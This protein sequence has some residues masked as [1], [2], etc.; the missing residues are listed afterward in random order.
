MRSSWG[1]GEAALTGE[2]TLL[3]IIGCAVVIFF[4][5]LALDGIES[6][7]EGARAYADRCFQQLLFA[8]DGAYFASNLS[9]KARPGYP[10]NNQ[11]YLIS[12]LT[13]L[14]VPSAPLKMEGAISYGSEPGAH[15]PIGRYD[16]RAVYP[17]ADAQFHLEV[18]RR[19]GH[20]R[21]DFLSANWQ[22]RSKADPIASP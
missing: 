22:E 2:G 20:W 5:W 17:S 18:T 4:G 12:S 10:P 11:K 21:I 3:L 14:G 8:H 1:C 19:Q 15:D 7:E 13:K 16:A 9:A 6:T